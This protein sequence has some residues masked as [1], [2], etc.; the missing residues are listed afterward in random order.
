VV[1]ADFYQIMKVR[2]DPSRRPLG[3]VRFALLLTA[4]AA[5]LVFLSLSSAGCG[6][7][8]PPPF[9]A[10]DG[11]PSGPTISGLS[12]DQSKV[13]EEF[14]YP[15]HFFISI[16]PISSDRM[17]RWIFYSRGK[18][19]DFDNGRLFGEEPAEDD[20]ASYPP[21]YLRPQDFTALT[22]PEEASRLLGEPLYTQEVRDSIMP[23]NTIIVYE[24][25]VLL[26]REGRLIGVDTQVSPPLLPG[27]E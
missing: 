19:L 26:Y 15:D 13:V 12:S 16:D 21:T 23:E 5:V 3:P 22:T 8:E 20:S 24:N 25:A 18:V 27:D 4:A 2:L 7:E 17:E 10:D 9:P 6:S 14:G 1:V 11:R